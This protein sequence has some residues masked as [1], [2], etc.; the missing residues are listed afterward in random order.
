KTWAFFESVVGPEDHWLPPDN[1]QEYPR[2]KV[3]HRMS[4]TNEGLFVLSAV[5]AHD[6]GFLGVHNL[7]DLL[8]RNLQ[9][10]DQLD[11]HCGHFFNWYVTT[12]LAPLAPRYISTADSGNL[13]AC[14]MTASQALRE[15]QRLPLWADRSTAGILDSVGLVEE[16]LARLQPRGARFGG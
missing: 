12:T 8:E 16:A 15:F 11:R 10:L 7:T 4:P 14:L 9:T 1:L 3:A 2:D 6:F 5:A 13:A